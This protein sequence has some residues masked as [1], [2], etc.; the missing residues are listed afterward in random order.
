LGVGKYLHSR[1]DD[2]VVEAKEEWEAEEQPV[3]KKI[4]GAGGF[5]NFDAW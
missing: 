5:G 1:Q 2:G 4:K 3:R